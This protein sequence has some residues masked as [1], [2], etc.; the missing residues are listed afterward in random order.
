MM[1]SLAHI[2]LIASKDLRLLL[3]DRTSLFF[4][5]AFPFLFV[6]LFG[7]ILSGF[8]SEDPR[9]VLRVATQEDSGS[10]SHLIVRAIETDD[11]AELE[12][13]EPIIV[14][15]TQ[16][17]QALQAVTDGKS[18]GF[19]SFPDGFTEAIS[20]GY[21]TSIEV[22]TDPDATYVRA[23]LTSMAEAISYQLGLQQVVRGAITGLMME[24]WLDSS[25][26]AH[27]MSEL[28]DYL[29]VQGS[30]PMRPSLSEY[31][32]EEVGRVEAEEP[33]DYVVPG[34]LVMFV[35][36]AAASSAEM[37]VRER[38]NHT[39]ERL[40]AAAVRRES[41]VLG[42][43]AGMAAKALV[44]IMVF[45]TAGILIFNMRLGQS[46]GAVILL[47]L[48]VAVMSAAF[49]IMLATL[50]R[51]ERSAAS[52]A[53]V[54]S[55]VLAAL[56]G[57]WWPLFITPRW[58]QFIAKATPHGW[59]TTGFNKLIL[60]SADAS[61]VIPEMLAVLGFAVVFG[62]IAIVRFRTSAV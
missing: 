11:E 4:N 46:P 14:W 9:L 16:Y 44:Q 37:I 20:R 29:A 42:T 51:T 30:A 12:P 50:A 43:F 17:D 3:R 59:A 61:A 25:D 60:F 45:W 62:T 57:C 8:G 48:L 6:A 34:Y 28:P 31:E 36:M 40:L 18:D 52:I 35:F 55:L 41:I 33:A 49:A 53:T 15:E 24:S 10:L 1:K 22:I 2:R 23:A 32:V 26:M 19:L 47:S 38:R 7:T 54:A 13:G 39:L 21:G 58:M 56:G 27:V 5:L